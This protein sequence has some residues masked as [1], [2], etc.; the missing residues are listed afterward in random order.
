MSK[1]L[2]LWPRTHPVGSVPN[3]SIEAVLRSLQDE[4]ERR[5]TTQELK[6]AR[7]QVLRGIRAGLWGA[8][9]CSCLQELRGALHAEV[10]DT[11]KHHIE[12]CNHD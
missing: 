10:F 7:R 6:R 2:A 9:D 12:E 11:N 8:Q 3:E 1:R 4:I 5:N